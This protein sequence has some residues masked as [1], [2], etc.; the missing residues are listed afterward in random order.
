[1]PTRLNAL[2][3]LNFLNNVLLQLLE[4]LPLEIRANICMMVSPV[5]MHGRTYAI[6]CRLDR[7]KWSCSLAWP[8]ARVE[9]MRL[10]FVGVYEGTGMLDPR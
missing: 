10:F 5:T 6:S 2:D 9:S 7:M 8:I 4:D 3:Y 1:M